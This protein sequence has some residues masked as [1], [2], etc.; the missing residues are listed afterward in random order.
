[1]GSVQDESGHNQGWTGGLSTQIR[2]QRRADLLLS[3]MDVRENQSVFEVGCG[4][5]EIA[6]HVA[7]K[8]GINVL[9]VDR[10][11]SFILEAKANT[12]GPNP[13][14][15]VV[16]FM[17]S[18]GHFDAPFDYLIGNGILHHLYYD[19]GAALKVMRQLLTD[20]GRIAF[21]EP[22]LHN[23]YVYLAFTQSRLRRM[24][25]LEPDEMAFTRHFAI[26]HLRNA[27]YT[28]IEVDYRDFLIPGVPNWL[29][30][31]LISL[32]RVA[33]RTPGVRHLAQSLFISAHVGSF[34]E[35]L[36][37]SS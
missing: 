18:L 33:E 36:H 32:G 27:G 11:E 9:G 15:E 19:L 28:D 31:P 37:A 23:P 34:G 24:A 4:R 21:L 20:E 29:I 26:Q 13:R 30:R 1:M 6:R 5:G 10:S 22:N 12:V 14:F 35:H 2:T 3:K 8:S 7:S 25:R 17:E 16:D